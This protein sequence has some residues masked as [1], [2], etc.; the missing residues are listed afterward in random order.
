MTL[1]RNTTPIRM[2]N[3]GRIIQDMIQVATQ[4]QNAAMRNKM[5][6]YI[7]HSMRQKTWS[8]TK[9]K[10]HHHLA[11]VTTSLALAM[12]N[13]TATLLSLTK[14]CNGLCTKWKRTSIRR[15]EKNELGFFD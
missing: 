13:S 10:I 9:T 1:T 7:A 4:E 2:R 14:L 5:I 8:G 11:F 15:I 3:Y 6:L 12:D